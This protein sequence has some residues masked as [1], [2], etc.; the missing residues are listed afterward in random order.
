VDLENILTLSFLVTIVAA[1]IR[2]ATPILFAALGESLAESAGIL[3]IG[4]EGMMALG[5]LAGFSAACWS[6]DPWLGFAIALIASGIAGLLAGAIMIERGA[7]HVVTGIVMNIFCLGLAGLA[8]R[9]F[10]GSR[11]GIPSIPRMQA[12]HLPVDI[13]V[14]GRALFSHLTIVY[15][16][17]ALVP[18]FW[19]MLKRTNWGLNVRAV[20]DNPA[21]AESA[22]IDVWRTR[23]MAITIGGAMAGL[24]G[25]TLSIAQ[26]GGY[27]DQ[28]TAGRGF[29]ALAVVVFGRLDPWRIAGISLIFGFA[30]ALQL[31]LQA[32]G[33]AVPHELLLALPYILT[34]IMVAAFAGKAAYPA[35]INRPYPRRRSLDLLSWAQS[36]KVVGWL[37]DWLAQAH[38]ISINVTLKGR[39]E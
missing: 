9:F 18:V 31:R 35:A 25:A 26:L 21:A 27:V 6:G 37:A 20:G 17:F 36:E 13:P 14:L 24:G 23:L 2:I 34:I 38:R 3:N 32:I 1:S 33:A 16:A 15:L 8:Y 29:I 10:F 4:I 19:F 39:K 28:M 5:A 22:G 30:E 7:D 11:S 12:W